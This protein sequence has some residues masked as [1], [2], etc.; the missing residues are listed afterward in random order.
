LGN[1]VVAEERR[2][3]ILDLLS[4]QGFASMAE[5]MQLTGAS[6]ATV[7]RDLVFLERG[8]GLE[9]T[10]G[11]AKAIARQSS[12]DEQFEI[13]RRRD[14]REKRVLGKLAA[15]RIPEGATVFLNDGS[16]TY[17]LAQSLT[18]RRLTVITSGLNIAQYLSAFSTIEVI[19]IGGSLRGASFGTDGPLAVD[20]IGVLHADLALIGVD[21]VT[22][23]GGAR[24]NSIEDAAV[25]R[26]MCRNA[27]RSV[28]LASSSKVDRD[29]RIRIVNWAEVDEL[30]ATSLPLEFRESLR[31]E[32]VYVTL[33]LGPD[34][35]STA[36]SG[37]TG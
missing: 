29:A 16:S 7:R 35:A 34:E 9:R 26:A 24:S 33:P 30:V 2:Q 37:P 13:R 28:V 11:G 20:A 10:R 14:R 31:G 17:A 6:E 19:V 32:G 23:S 21:G 15:G 27:E 3:S 36:S 22:L 4:H 1:R 8:G 5:V 12:L 25:A 18:H